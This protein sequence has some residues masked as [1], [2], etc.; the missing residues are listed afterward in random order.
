M[1]ESIVAKRLTRN[2]QYKLTYLRIFESY[3]EMDPGKDVGE[4][5]HSLIEGLQSTI[6][7]LSSYLR[8]LDVGAQGLELNDKLIAQAAG[9]DTLESRLKFIYDGLS[10]AVS[11]YKT[12]LVDKQMT[13]DLRLRQLLLELGEIDAAKMWRTEAV[14]GMLHVSVKLESTDSDEE[15]MEAEPPQEEV[16]RSRLAEDVIRAPRQRGGAKRWP[17]TSGPRR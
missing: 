7:M 15:P 6:S 12:Q 9:R 5:L 1:A 2:L 10:R 17:K 14:M 11:W 4:L 16:W 13:S 8:G 3:L